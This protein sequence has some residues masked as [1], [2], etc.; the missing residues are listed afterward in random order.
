MR[1]AVCSLAPGVAYPTFKKQIM[2]T[3]LVLFLFVAFLLG[4]IAFS[5]WLFVLLLILV[6]IMKLTDDD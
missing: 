5:P 4:L 1:C 3:A 2:K 6:A